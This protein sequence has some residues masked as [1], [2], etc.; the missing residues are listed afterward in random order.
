ME[1]ELMLANVE[2]NMPLL[3][4]DSC[5]RQMICELQKFIVICNI[6]QEREMNEI[7]QF[8][9][10][11]QPQKYVNTNNMVILYSLIT[12]WNIHPENFWKTT[13]SMYYPLH[14]GAMVNHIKKQKRI[15][16]KLI[17]EKF[18]G[19]HPALL[20]LLVD[21]LHN[22]Y[23]FQ[24]FCV[25]FFL[26]KWPFNEKYYSKKTLMLYRGIYRDDPYDDLLSLAIE[27]LWISVH[28]IDLAMKQENPK[29][30][31]SAR[32]YELFL[33]ELKSRNLL[34][35]KYIPELPHVE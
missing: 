22:K 23:E 34:P 24:I 21:E 10:C 5:L 35:D 16:G 13:R 4:I 26:L 31:L 30:Y 32:D 20:S 1:L 28:D 2:K 9:T 12:F 8:F 33:L 25:T 19:T 6:P 14:F 18:I 7:Y 11:D 29:T 17:L 27:L 3:A 15:S